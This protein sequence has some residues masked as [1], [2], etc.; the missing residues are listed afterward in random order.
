MRDY[1]AETEKRVEFIR[2]VLRESGARGVVFGNSGGKDASLTGILCKF[3]CT[4]TLGLIMPC[5]SERNL[6]DDFRDATDV[7][8][9]FQIESRTVYLTVATAA[10]KYAVGEAAE[11][12]AAAAINIAPRLR[13]AALYAVAASEGRLV[14]G[15]GNR[16]ERY[17]GYFTKWGDGA[18]DFN[19][20]AD[21]TVTE[22]Y[23]FLKHLGAP[24]E[25]IGKAP[26]AGLY[27]G[28]TDEGDMGVTYKSIDEFLFSG[29]CPD[30]DMEIIA[31][32]HQA[33]GHKRSPPKVYADR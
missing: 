12:T 21:L 19:P 28:Q 17:M 31:R 11:L 7:A 4:D 3:A 20:I 9:Q 23:E 14:A 2:E 8:R 15:T 30:A 25:I 16:S 24:R 26:S 22:V 27:E 1:Q 5:G 6:G 32:F 33:S 13:M 10:L 29:K 18:F